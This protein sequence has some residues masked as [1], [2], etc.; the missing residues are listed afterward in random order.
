LEEISRKKEVDEMKTLTKEFGFLRLDQAPLPAPAGTWSIGSTSGSGWRQP[1]AGV[2]LALN[3]MYFDLKGMAIDDLTLFFEGAAVQDINNPAVFNQ[4]AGDTVTIVDVMSAIPLTD[5][6]Y[7]LLG[8]WGNMAQNPSGDSL[9]FEQTI[10]LRIRSY[11]VDVDTAAWGSMV[12]VSD[13]QLGSLSPTASDRV[14]CARVVSVGTPT[15][16]TQI[17]VFGSRYLLRANAKAEAEYEYLMR[18]KR[19]YELQQRFDRD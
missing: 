5:T 9:T 3:T 2:G 10:Y 4:A 6:E 7:S 15:T 14:Y 13:N 8:V 12:L 11:V 16:S 19:S 17:D 1:T 18:L